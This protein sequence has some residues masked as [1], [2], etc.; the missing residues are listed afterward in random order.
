MANQATRQLVGSTKL[1]FRVP[2]ELVI[3]YR[4]ITKSA[5][6]A[7]AFS[8]RLPASMSSEPPS[9]P[10]LPERTGKATAAEELGR[11]GIPARGLSRELAAAYL[12]ISAGTFDALVAE[13]LLPSPKRLKRRRIWDR[14]ALDRAFAM[15]PDENGIII[16]SDE[17][18]DIWSQAAV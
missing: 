4:E 17:P 18:D 12:G 8:S 3:R 11:M 9:V 5:G 7:G 2:S 13:G 14:L 1:G 6:I 10:R 15:I 16:A